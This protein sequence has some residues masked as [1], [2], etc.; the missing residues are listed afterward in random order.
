MPEHADFIAPSPMD[1][2]TAEFTAVEPRDS[3]RWLVVNWWRLWWSVA[4]N[5]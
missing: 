2:P 4:R 5:P 1:D 3:W